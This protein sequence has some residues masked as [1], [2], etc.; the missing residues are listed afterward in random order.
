MTTR[1]LSSGWCPRILPPVSGTLNRG[2]GLSKVRSLFFRGLT[3]RISHQHRQ[4]PGGAS[5]S[6]PWITFTWPLNNR[7]NGSVP[8]PNFTNTPARS[9]PEQPPVPILTRRGAES[10]CADVV[11]CLVEG[12]QKIM[13]RL[14]IARRDIPQAPGLFN[15][16]H[17][18][19][20]ECRFIEDIFGEEG[21]GQSL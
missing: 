4:R 10:V 11:L 1:G 19:R 14:H 13:G 16:L 7:A 20:R 18:R 8:C 2:S 9:L 15:N 6:T 17:A 12:H 3:G 21:I 5:R